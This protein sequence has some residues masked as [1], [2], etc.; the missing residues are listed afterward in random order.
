MDKVRSD[1]LREKRKNRTKNEEKTRE[2]G[3]LGGENVA[4][5]NT[6]Q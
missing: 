1:A 6:I 5:I 4:Q 3:L 2:R